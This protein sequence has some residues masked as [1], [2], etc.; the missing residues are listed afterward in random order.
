MTATLIATDFNALTKS[1]GLKADLRRANGPIEVD[2]RVIVQDPLEEEARWATVRSISGNNVTM[3]VIWD[4]P[5]FFH[6][7]GSAV[8]SSRAQP[9][10]V[11]MESNTIVHL[12][13][14]LDSGKLT[15]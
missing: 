9:E 5:L 15:A 10:A 3:D 12:S 7:S 1:G 14:L 11:A 13:E 8:E 6:P 2:M 4:V